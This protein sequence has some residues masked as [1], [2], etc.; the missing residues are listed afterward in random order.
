[1]EKTTF[2]ETN[3]WGSSQSQ[4]PRHSTEHLLRVSL[5][6]KQEQWAATDVHGWPWPHECAFFMIFAANIIFDGE[7]EIFVVK[8]ALL[9]SK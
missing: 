7:N 5:R 2:G 9:F 6:R 1:M 8:L 4:D 3:P